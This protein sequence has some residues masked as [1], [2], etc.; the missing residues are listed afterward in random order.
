M[1]EIIRELCER[2]SVE[3]DNAKLL[4]LIREIN[5]L[6]DEEVTNKNAQRALPPAGRTRSLNS[7]KT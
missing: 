2:A 3:K 7:M 4:K 5:R 1:N 6:M